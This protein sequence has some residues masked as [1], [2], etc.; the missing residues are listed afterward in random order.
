MAHRRHTGK[1][2][3]T[4]CMLCIGLI[5]FMPVMWTFMN[6]IKESA[7]ISENFLA[8]PTSLYLENFV[9]AIDRM[10]FFTALR[11][12]LVIAVCA[13]VCAVFV[14][15]LAA[16]GISHLK[17]KLGNGFYMYFVLGQLIPF[18]VVMVCISVMATKVHLTNSLLGII[19]LDT[20][21]FSA[22]GVL[23]FVG[24]LKSVPFELEEAGMID[25]CGPVKTMLNIVFPLVKPATVT[26]GVLFFLWSW[27][28]F[29]LPSILISETDLR[30]LTVN[31]YM[32][33]GATSTEWN[34]FIA[35]LTMCIIPTILLYIGAQKYIT[36][37][38][39]LGALK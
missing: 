39:T 14:S 11:N 6:S 32:F 1:I 12:S 31:L 38:L 36:S 26:L 28:D 10:H 27:N 29:L 24:F 17:G 23:T 13:T 5:F 35:G 34:L 19:L 15:F 4:L 21:F 9:E 3:A 37:G 2:L 20:G 16:Y 25:G 18:H 30:P 8:L 7:A 33:K 22:F